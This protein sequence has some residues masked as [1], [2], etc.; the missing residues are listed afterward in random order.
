[1]KSKI[2]CQTPFKGTVALELDFC[3]FDPVFKD[4]LGCNFC[5]F[6][7]NSPISAQ[8]YVFSFLLAHSSFANKK[9][10]A[11]SLNSTDTFGAFFSFGAFSICA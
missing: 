2:L 7:E 9:L 3:S 1:M 11:Y 10:S 5:F 6:V 8:F 4:D